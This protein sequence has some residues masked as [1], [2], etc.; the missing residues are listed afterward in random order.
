MYYQ[1]QTEN[2]LLDSE[3]ITKIEWPT[4]YG[5]DLIFTRVKL[6]NFRIKI[7]NKK[8]FYKNNLEFCPQMLIF[9]ISL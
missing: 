2:G 3:G 5:Q 8:T 4:Q 7:E 9:N 6:K 1:S